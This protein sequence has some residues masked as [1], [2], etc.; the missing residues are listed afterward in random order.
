MGWLCECFVFYNVG[1]VSETV[2]TTVSFEEAESEVGDDTESV[3]SGSSGEEDSS[4]I[5]KTSRWGWVFFM[6]A[7]LLCLLNPAYLA[8]TFSHSRQVSGACCA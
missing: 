6:W 5:G 4:I 3:S 1:G 8:N 7:L 2:T